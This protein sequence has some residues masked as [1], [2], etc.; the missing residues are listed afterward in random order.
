VHVVL[1]GDDAGARR[2]EPAKPLEQERLSQVDRGVEGER[3][4]RAE[5]AEQEAIEDEPVR[6]RKEG[7]ARRPFL[8]L[9]ERQHPVQRVTNSIPA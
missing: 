1:R 8:D 3:R 4:R 2:G 9:V 6:R 5:Q 7:G